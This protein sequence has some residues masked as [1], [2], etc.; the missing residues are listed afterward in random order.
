MKK[1]IIL[2]ILLVTSLLL[3]IGCTNNNDKNQV[4]ETKTNETKTVESEKE[5]YI[6]KVQ[7]LQKIEETTEDL[8]FSVE[9]LYEQMDS[10]VRYQVVIDN[11]TVDI[12]NILAL[13]IHDKQTDDVFP[14]VGIFDEKVDL[15]KEETPSGVILVGYIPYEG[16]MDDFEC[17][18]K[19]LISYEKEDNEYTSYYVTKK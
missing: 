8:P 7:E 4:E 1:K 5:I 14:S 12:T 9:V 19:V 6:K 10:E 11:P 18:M 3:I 16:E 15:K 2:V 13:A 17:E